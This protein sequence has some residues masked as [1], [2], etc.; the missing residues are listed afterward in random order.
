MVVTYKKNIIFI[1]LKLLRE[2]IVD[3]KLNIL[4][5]IILNIR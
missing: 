5:K 2:I 1:Y 4:I 3:N